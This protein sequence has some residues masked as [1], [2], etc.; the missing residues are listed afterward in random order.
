MLLGLE[1]RGFSYLL[2]LKPLDG[3]ES[4][5]EAMLEGF[6]A[7]DELKKEILHMEVGCHNYW[8]PYYKVM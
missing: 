7:R 6:G 3:F 5:E 2:G 4:I 8:T 1:L